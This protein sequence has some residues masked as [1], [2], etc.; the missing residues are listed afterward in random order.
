MRKIMIILF[1]FPMFLWGAIQ[2]KRSLSKVC[3]QIK[4]KKS[5]IIKSSRGKVKCKKKNK[6]KVDLQPGNSATPCMAGRVLHYPRNINY[7]IV[8][9]M[10]EFCNWSSQ[11]CWACHLWALRSGI[12]TLL[13]NWRLG[14]VLQVPFVL[15]VSVKFHQKLVGFESLRCFKNF[16][17]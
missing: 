12:D 6:V 4:C 10:I 17:W 14:A 2:G 1:F 3:Q 11:I 16:M 15:E 8:F 5:E 7:F 9:M 13:Y